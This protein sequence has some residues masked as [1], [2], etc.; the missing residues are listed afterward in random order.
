MTLPGLAVTVGFEPERKADAKL[1][2]S[3]RETASHLRISKRLGKACTT[4]PR[5]QK[6]PS[7]GGDFFV[8]GGDG[9]I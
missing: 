4:S 5:K 3:L 9:G 6:I 8:C 7:P 1:S 2:R